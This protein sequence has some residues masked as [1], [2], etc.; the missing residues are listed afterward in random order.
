M[1]HGVSQGYCEEFR[2]DISRDVK[3]RFDHIGPQKFYSGYRLS[4]R[5]RFGSGSLVGCWARALAMKLCLHS[6]LCFYLDG[7]WGRGYSSSSYSLTAGKM[8]Y[9]FGDLGT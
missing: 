9:Y 5:R 2:R 3:V 6:T 8:R 7:L 1:G 4:I